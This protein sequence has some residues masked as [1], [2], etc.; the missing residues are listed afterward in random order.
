MSGDTKSTMRGGRAAEAM[1]DH[2]S[3][4][5]E[6]T[7]KERAVFQT[8]PGPISAWK[9]VGSALASAEVMKPTIHSVT[10]LKESQTFRQCLTD[11]GCARGRVELPGV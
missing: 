11:L 9:N 3:R 8:D 4:R 6:P 7:E 2:T 1:E 5:W 10:F